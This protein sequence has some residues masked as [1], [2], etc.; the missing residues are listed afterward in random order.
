MLTVDTMRAVVPKGIKK[1]IDQGFIDKINGALDDPN[2][3][4]TMRDNI[5]GYADVLADGRYKMDDYIS[6]VKYVSYKAM[7]KTNIASYVA[8]F[9]DRYAAYLENG[10]SQKDIASYVTSYNKNK[11]V[12]KIYEQTL[13][14]THILNAGA[15]QDAINHQRSIMCNPDASFKVQSDA[16]NSLMV[17]LKPPTAAKLEVEIG[18]K[19]STALSELKEITAAMAKQVIDSIESGTMT[20]LEAA[21][22][23]V[24]RPVTFDENGEVV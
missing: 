7:N 22:Q 9:P 20:A 10:T 11:L 18:V 13:I 6:A 12:N 16:A 15:F 1:R 5:L 19:D 8:T 4:D 17:H 14:P 21:E 2:V 3:A 23:R 24:H